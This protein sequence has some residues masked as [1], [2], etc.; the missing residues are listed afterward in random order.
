M[1]VRDNL[2]SAMLSDSMDAVS[3]FLAAQKYTDIIPGGNYDKRKRLF[4][5]IVQAGLFI[6]TTRNRKG[7]HIFSQLSNVARVLH[8]FFRSHLHRE[9]RPTGKNILSSR[10][11][12]IY[13]DIQVDRT[14]S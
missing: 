5:K 7:E 14:M 13:R 1:S 8:R 9:R 4:D 2:A 10:S 12:A 11:I 6:E 3:C